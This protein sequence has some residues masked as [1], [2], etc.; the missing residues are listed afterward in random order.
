MHKWA[1]YITNV[2]Q[3]VIGVTCLFKASN[4]SSL[5]SL[6]AVMFI[7]SKPGTWNSFSMVRK[8]FRTSQD[9]YAKSPESNLIPTALY[10]HHTSLVTEDHIVK[11]CAFDASSSI[12]CTQWWLNGQSSLLQS[13]HRFWDHALSNPSQKIIM[14]SFVEFTSFTFSGWIQLHEANNMTRMQYQLPLRLKGMKTIS[15]FKK[16]NR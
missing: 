13:Q 5:R 12:S 4:V 10:L 16:E 14:R 2:K 1:R 8:N 15:F 7:L 11:I 3:V 6:L 9:K